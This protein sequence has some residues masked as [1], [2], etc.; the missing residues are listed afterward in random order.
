[1]DRQK[2]SI[3]RTNNHV[4]R[5]RWGC[6]GFTATELLV[7]VAILATVGGIA[8][9]QVVGALD[10]LRTTGAARLVST[11]LQK[12]RMEA[13]L[14]SRDVALRFT[15]EGSGYRFAFYV[16]GNG[17][18]VLTRDIDRGVDRPLGSV[19][20][21]RQ[22]FPGIE[23]GTLPGLP[24]IDPGGV[25]PG[26]DPIRLGSSNSVTFTARGTSSTGSLYIRGRRAQMAVR[27]YGDTG[28]T[29]LLK[30]DVRTFQW[31]PL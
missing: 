15:P 4:D 24:A 31:R 17:N 29:R 26:N 1:M 9:P 10:D 5:S 18:G 25:P 3:A 11:R 30:F 20:R 12:A 16:D 22:N 7:V 21:L 14:R 27:I 13:I 19:E 6:V 28:K 23:F 8:M 2:R